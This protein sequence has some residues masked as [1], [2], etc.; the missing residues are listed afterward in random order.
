[1]IRRPPRST[2]TAPLLP[3][4]TLF[5]SVS[6]AGCRDQA[7]RKRRAHMPPSKQAGCHAFAAGRVIRE[8]AAIPLPRLPR[9]RGE[10]VVH[11]EGEQQHRPLMAHQCHADPRDD[12]RSEEH[13]SEPPVTTAHL[14]CRLLL[15]KTKTKTKK[16]H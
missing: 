2:R 6:F 12:F 1:M 4:T 3:Y 15:E 8:A 5:R 16:M 14:V 7:A 13:T 9:A 11:H 10:V